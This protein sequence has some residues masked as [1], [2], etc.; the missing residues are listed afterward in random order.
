MRARR[1]P[2]LS[3]VAVF[4]VTLHTLLWGAVAPVLAVPANDPF[5]VICHSEATAAADQTPNHGPLAPAYA[6]DHCNL[7][8][9]IAPPVPNTTPAGQFMPARILQV[10]SPVSIA[11]HDDLTADPKLARGPP[12][13]A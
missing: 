12:A 9:A 6:C 7:C 13:F 5:T 4:A 1:R 10:L 2:I 3:V 11:R 8:S